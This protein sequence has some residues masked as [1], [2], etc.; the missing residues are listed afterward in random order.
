MG[1]SANSRV[2]TQLKAD[3]TGH[4]IEVPASDTATTLGAAILAGVGTGFYA[5]FPAAVAQ[6]VAVRRTH[7]PDESLR[8]VYGLGYARYRE[9]YERLSPMMAQA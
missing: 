1:G 9:L 3:I 2:W 7:Q 5:G 6:T 4:P 8:D